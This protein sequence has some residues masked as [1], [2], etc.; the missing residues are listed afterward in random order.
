M[1][2]RFLGGVDAP[3]DARDVQDVQGVGDL[4]DVED[5]LAKSPFSR[6]ETSTWE[7]STRYSVDQVVGLQFSRACS[8]PAL[9]GDRKD[10]FEAELRRA[11]LD[12]DPGGTYVRTV[13]VAATVATRPRR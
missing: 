8:G 10:A 2:A 7:R 5:R 13:T 9:S 12:H 3:Y 11:L 6:V 4:R 1:C